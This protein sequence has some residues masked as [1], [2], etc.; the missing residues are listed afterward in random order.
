MNILFFGDIMGRPG[1]EAIKKTIHEFKE[2]Y[3][4]DLILANGENLAH[5][6][7]VTAHTLE[8]VMSLG[9]DFFTSGNHI[10]DRKNDREISEKYGNVFVR[11]LNFKKTLFGDGYKILNVGGEKVLIANI[12]GKDFMKGEYD[13]PFLAME[14]LF[15]AVGG[16]V[17]IKIVDF[18]AETT[19]E[20]RAMGF[21]LSGKVSVVLGTHTHVPTADEQIIDSKTGYISDVG[22]VG[23]FD[24]VLGMDKNGAIEYFRTGSKKNLELSENIILEMNAVFLEIDNKTGNCVKI[25]RVRKID[26]K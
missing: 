19:S 12:I 7:G 15:S 25:E 4:P 8:E 16:G 26:I 1:R 3:K 23:A 21:F 17:K 18:H 5:G 9:V 2:K 6:S 20:K 24:S 22:M 13:S 10:F 11:P 14:N